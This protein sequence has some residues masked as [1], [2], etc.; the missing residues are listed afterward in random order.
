M[1]QQYGT[2]KVNP[3][4]P[5]VTTDAKFRLPQH[6]ID[7]GY[8]KRWDQVLYEEAKE[9]AE[10]RGETVDPDAGFLSP[11][12]KGSGYAGPLRNAVGSN[13]TEWSQSGS[14][15][16]EGGPIV[17]YPL[18]VPG[19]D[20][21]DVRW[22]LSR[23]FDLPRDSDQF[24]ESDRAS[25]E[26]IER[27]ARA[28]ARKR[29]EQGLSPFASAGEEDRDLYR[30]HSLET[31]DFYDYNAA[32]AAG[33]RPGKDG[34]WSSE[35]KLEG[36]PTMVVGG[37]HTQTGE[38]VPGT[39]RM[40]EQE[41]INKGWRPEDARSLA[42]MPEPATD[43]INKPLSRRP[44]MPQQYDEQIREL[45]R[46]IQR[47]K[48]LSAAEYDSPAYDVP[49]ELSD[50]DRERVIQSVRT[51]GDLRR[52][53]AAP[54]SSPQE[55]GLDALPG[56]LERL[57]ELRG[58]GQG[59]PDAFPD[60][61]LDSPG[62]VPGGGIESVYRAEE[63]EAEEIRR[64]LGFDAPGTIFEHEDDRKERWRRE[65]PRAPEEENRRMWDYR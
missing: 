47:L 7:R 37:F 5:S 31:N 40:G 30:E 33:A 13:M 54:W 46:E 57:E 27:V 42:A 24:T 2:R 58:L 48:A 49:Q 36:H 25:M 62:I 51:R 43:E 20:S 28:H 10:A 55:S 32:I 60:P 59:P 1:A 38:R 50:A 34:H 19:M 16:A 26:R 63:R 9:K 22:M 35:W 44:L 52:S 3:L 14:L 61:D 17:E 29:I 39:R 6:L 11:N 65:N 4:T 64:L 56:F 12:Y 53:Q 21:A 15:Y 18:I 8:G 23:G 41:L 45:E